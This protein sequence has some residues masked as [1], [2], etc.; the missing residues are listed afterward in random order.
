MKNI[1]LLFCVFLASCGGAPSNETY[2]KSADS[3]AGGG[4]NPKPRLIMSSSLGTPD[5]TGPVF[6]PKVIYCLSTDCDTV[7]VG[8]SGPGPVPASPR[9]ILQGKTAVAVPA[10]TDFKIEVYFDLDSTR[11][12][13]ASAL[14]KVQP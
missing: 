3:S 8:G 4:I 11:L 2:S 10:G 6:H 1:I 12:L 14:K 5:T 7:S 9:I 13:K